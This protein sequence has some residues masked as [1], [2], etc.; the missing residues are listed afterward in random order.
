MGMLVLVTSIPKTVFITFSEV[1]LIVFLLLTIDSA[2]KKEVR[3]IKIPRRD[4]TIF[5]INNNLKIQLKIT[6]FVPTNVANI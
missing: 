2:P 4:K 3:S 6:I 1:G 5:R